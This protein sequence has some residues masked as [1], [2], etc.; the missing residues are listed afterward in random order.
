MIKSKQ[1]TQSDFKKVSDFLKL[2]YDEMSSNW[3]I[4]RWNFCRYFAQNRLGVFDIWPST[5][6]MWVDDNDKIIAIV[7]S[8]GEQKGEAF[9]Q[10]RPMD[11]DEQLINE[12]IDFAEENLCISKDGSNHL[13]I[14]PN[15]ICKNNIIN[16]LTNRG[17]SQE[18]RFETDSSMNI[19]GIFNVELPEGFRIIEAKDVSVSSRGLAHGKAFGN[20][21][22]DTP[23]YLEERIIGYTGLVKAPDYKGDLDL[24]IIDKKGEIASFTTVW[25]DE[26]NSIGI[27]EPVGTIPKY[28]RLGLGKAVIYEGINRIK[29]LGAKKIHVGSNQN[30]YKAIGFNVEA[31]TEIWYKRFD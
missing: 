31:T 12:M 30:F 3:Y 29:R 1:F 27:L 13:Y 7:C 18:E 6:G 21:D 17:Y 24:C 2:T 15:N 20:T 16:V 10:L 4:D 11:Y 9:F 5:V 19:E 28:R 23:E 26:V 22:S 25:Y 8:E 14:R